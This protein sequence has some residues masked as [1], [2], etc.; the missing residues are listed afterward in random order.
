VAQR[1]EPTKV[2]GWDVVVRDANGLGDINTV[3]ITLG[4]DDDLGLLYRSNEGCSS[5]DGRLTATENCLGTIVGDELHITFDFEVMWQMTSSG[6]NIGALQVRSYDE[7]GFT[8]YDEVNAWTFERDLTVAI[9]SMEDIS[10]DVEKST[11]GPLT[12]NTALKV[13][14]LIQITGTVEHTT[15]GEAY[16]GTVALRWDGQFQASNWVGGQTVIVENGVFVTTFSVPET[17]GKIFDAELEIWDPIENER[18]LV[19]E[20]PDLIID[21]D[22]PLLLTSTF[23]QVSRFDLRQVDIGANIEEPQ[24]WTNG[25]AMTCQVTSTTVE[26]EPITLVREPMDVFDGRTLFSFRFNFSESGQPS[27]LGSQA[28]L[29]CWASGI[30]DAGW[31]LVAQGTNSKESPWTSISL[32]ST[33]PDLQISKVSFDDELVAGTEVAATIQIFNS[34]ERIEDSFNVSVF[35]N[36]GESNTLIAQRAFAGLD[37]S[38]AGSMRILV[39]I[40]DGSWLLNVVIDSDGVIAELNEMNNNWSE[41]YDSSGQGFS[42]V[43]LVAGGSLVG[44]VAAAAVMLRLRKAPSSGIDTPDEGKE[45]NK[46]VPTIEK[47]TGPTNVSAPNTGPKKRG[48]PPAQ[49]KPVPVEQSPAEAAAAQFAAL[50]SLTPTIEVERVGSWESLPA[51]GDYDYTTEGTFYVGETCGRWKLLDDGQFEKIE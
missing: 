30:D 10:G 24:S 46:D 12:T 43:I 3:R 29:N 51:G 15:S 35:L 2:S 19:N 1:L 9:D 32:T 44:I 20:F 16:T 34:G 50:D 36:K 48:P 38:E 25:L 39:D 6:I 21:G 8:F 42:S 23:N 13:N 26:W 31:N 4:G 5:L 7:D 47:K 22:A 49:P 14:D 33:G 37:T 17:S 27:L 41:S 11:A 40:P 18:F 28:N 45:E